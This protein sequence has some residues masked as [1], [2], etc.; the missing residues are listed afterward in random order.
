M[1]KKIAAI[2]AE[3]GKKYNANDDKDGHKQKRGSTGAMKDEDNENESDEDDHPSNASEKGGALSALGALADA[4][5]A[6]TAA[7]VKAIRK[8]QK[9]TEADLEEAADLAAA[10][11]PETPFSAMGMLSET[12]WKSNTPQAENQSFLLPGFGYG[13]SAKQTLALQ[14]TVPNDAN[15]WSLNICP[16]RDWQ[17]SNIL[18]HFNPRYKKRTVVM[19]DKQGTWGP[20]RTRPFGTATSKTDGLLAKE[21]ELLIQIRPQGFVVFANGMFNGFFP[22]RRNPLTTSTDRENSNSMY[23]GGDSPIA[24]LTADLKLLVLAK[25]ANGNVQDIILNK[26]SCVV[27]FDYIELTAVS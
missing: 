8:K 27:F 6:A 24:D 14:L 10:L 20:A 12:V 1:D 23:G 22:H 19:A 4:A 26:V 13:I 25:D 3:Q 16:A 5:A 9:V 15:S 17:N 11:D 2:L 18:M 7:P 21:I